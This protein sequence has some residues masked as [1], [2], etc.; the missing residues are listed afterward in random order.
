MVNLHCWVNKAFCI[1]MSNEEDYAGSYLRF[2]HGGGLVGA[3]DWAVVNETLGD[4]SGDGFG[5]GEHRNT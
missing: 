3:T 2:V 5:G 4:E 1:S